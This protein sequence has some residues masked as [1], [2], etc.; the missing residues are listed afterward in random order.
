MT[1]VMGSQQIYEVQHSGQTQQLTFSSPRPAQAQPPRL[2]RQSID[3]RSLPLAQR[4]SCIPGALAARFE[5]GTLALVQVRP[6]CTTSLRLRGWQLTAVRGLWAPAR[7][8]PPCS[9][10]LP[11][12]ETV[13]AQKQPVWGLIGRLRRRGQQVS[14]D[15]REFAQSLCVPTGR[16]SSRHPTIGVF[17]PSKAVLWQPSGQRGCV[18]SN[19][20]PLAAR[21]I[22]VKSVPNYRSRS[23]ALHA[24]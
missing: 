21:N 10:I 14:S 13:H 12:R 1:A 3:L 16:Q 19:R 9:L 4:L 8:A 6:L 23:S 2:G 11:P 15:A 5:P 22:C 24:L 7:S 18:L 17:D 20:R